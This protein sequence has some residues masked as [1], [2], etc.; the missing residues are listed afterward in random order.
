MKC[1]VPP[2]G[3]G[4][5]NG[6]YAHP[7]PPADTSTSS[8]HLRPSLTL[9]LHCSDCLRSVQSSLEGISHRRRSAVVPSKSL[10]SGTSEAGPRCSEA[11]HWAVRSDLFTRSKQAFFYSIKS[12]R[13]SLTRSNLAEVPVTRSKRVISSSV[14]LLVAR[15]A[16]SEVR[17]SHFHRV[18]HSSFLIM[19]R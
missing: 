4:N 18:K 3:N 10:P 16:V 14:L 13:R 19:G 12:P 6:D 11:Y 1:R 2:D 17:G 9:P 7:H 15:T 5:G 8:A